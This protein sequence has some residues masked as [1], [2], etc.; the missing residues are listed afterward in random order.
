MVVRPLAARALSRLATVSCIALAVAAASTAAGCAA[1]APVEEEVGSSADELR[2]PHPRLA[3]L[4]DVTG[5]AMG[6]CE[7]RLSG[8]A[9]RSTNGRNAGLEAR[10]VYDRFFLPKR[11]TTAAGWGWRAATAEEV[12]TIAKQP[13]ILPLPTGADRAPKDAY[14]A[15]MA[16]QPDPWGTLER[17]KA[18]GN[19]YYTPPA[20]MPFVRNGDP[21]GGER[22]LA[23]LARHGSDE[24]LPMTDKARAKYYEEQNP[25]DWQAAAMTHYQPPSGAQSSDIMASN[26][27]WRVLLAPWQME[28]ALADCASDPEIPCID[29]VAAL[30]DADLYRVYDVRFVRVPAAGGYEVSRTF[31]VVVVDSGHAIDLQST[32]G[33][34]AT[35]AV[36]GA[37]TPDRRATPMLKTYGNAGP[38]LLWRLEVGGQLSNALGAGPGSLPGL[39]RYAL[40]NGKSPADRPAEGS[41]TDVNNGE[42]KCVE[43]N[44]RKKTVKCMNL[45]WQTYTFGCRIPGRPAVP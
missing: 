18:L 2:G 24:A 36:T 25:F 35:D 9:L 44:G 14:K 27:V 6:A 3:H 1:D 15:W 5:L 33:P 42:W 11:P 21:L 20:V 30:S 10:K 8:C 23:I 34:G 13:P 17:R 12:A 31:R 38:K 41:C 32:F 40:N 29:A 28:Q 45:L 26:F 4:P 39:V 19:V 37:P 43:E 7:N 16:L 22:N